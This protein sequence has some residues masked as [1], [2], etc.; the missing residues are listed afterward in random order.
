VKE[1]GT[2]SSPIILVKLTSKNKGGTFQHDSV[3]DKGDNFSAAV[4]FWQ[5]TQVMKH[6]F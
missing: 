5:Y 4:S 3:S 1:Y 2:K 6:I